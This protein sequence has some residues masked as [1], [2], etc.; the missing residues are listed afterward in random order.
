M[1]IESPWDLFNVAEE[2]YS[3]LPEG[4]TLRIFLDTNEMSTGSAREMALPDEL[5]FF[6]AMQRDN[7]SKLPFF[8]ITSS[9]SGYRI[10]DRLENR[11]LYFHKVIMNSWDEEELEVL[12]ADV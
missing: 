4:K 2:L 1:R 10:I 6:S 12:Y 9:P 5:V 11:G 8:V 3:E 7:T